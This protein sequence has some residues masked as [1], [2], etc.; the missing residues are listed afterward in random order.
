MSAECIP[1]K[2]NNNEKVRV[3]GSSDMGWSTRGSGRQYDGL[4]GF[5]YIIGTESGKVIGYATRNRK[6]R[7]W[8][9]GDAK[10]DHDCRKIFCGSAKAMEPNVIVE[11]VCKNPILKDKNVENGV[12][13]GDNDNSSI[14]AIRQ[15]TDHKFYS[16]AIKITLQK[17][18]KTYYI[19]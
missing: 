16:K 1:D 11:L 6:C 7:L 17:A 4:S 15:E 13:V 10:D 12:F 5:A 3:S 19:T 9:K 8:D 18:L 14:C 2:N